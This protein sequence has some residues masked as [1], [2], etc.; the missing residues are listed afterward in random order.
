[1]AAFCPVGMAWEDGVVS[2]AGWLAVAVLVGM[3]GELRAAEGPKAVAAWPAGLMEVRMAFDAPA[4]PALAKAVLSSRIKFGQADPKAQATTEGALN[5]AA[6]RLDDGG[7]TLVLVTDPHPR[8]S[9]Y[10][11]RLPTNP[12]QEVTYTLGGVE[13]TWAKDADAQPEWTGWLPGYDLAAAR[14][15]LGQSATHEKLWILLESPGRLTLRSFAS[16]PQGQGSLDLAGKGLLEGVYGSSNAEVAQDNTKASLAYESTGETQELA[17][18]LATGPGAALSLTLKGKPLAQSSLSLPWAPPPVNGP[19]FT[20]PPAALLTGGDWAKGQAVFKGQQAKCANCHRVR[21]EGGTIGPDLTGLVGRDRAWVYRN[22]AEP[23]AAIHPDYVSWTV[24][25]KDG[26]VAMGVVRARGSEAIVV[27]DT[28]AKV[29]EFSRQDI[30]E[31]RPSGSSIMPVGL[32]GAIGE[33]G[34]KDLLKY[35]TSAN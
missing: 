33:Q 9:T 25:L 5:I 12:V 29:S 24:A 35:L 23:S 22:I 15:I 7:R 27:S 16:L 32:L 14:T 17:V 34:V 30:E 2:R 8:E 18:T 6:A 1:M 13:A 11:L 10:R 26:R 4:D 28:D 20:D 3:A 31:I 21:G 19:A